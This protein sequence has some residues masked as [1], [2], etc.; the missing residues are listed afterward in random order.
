MELDIQ[1]IKSLSL[2]Q[3]LTSTSIN[4][5][6]VVSPREGNIVNGFE[7]LGVVPMDTKDGMLQQARVP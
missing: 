3:C 1:Q 5:G 2:P 4:K 7:D 6:V